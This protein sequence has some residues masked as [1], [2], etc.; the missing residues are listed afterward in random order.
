MDDCLFCKINAGDIPG[1]VIA[2]NANYLA[3]RDI[4]P[5][6]DTHV[7]VIPREHHDNLDRFLANGGDAHDMLQFV[8]QTAEGLGVGGKYRLIVNV[9]EQAGQVVHHLHWHILAGGRLPGF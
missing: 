5:K 4:A 8:S 3:F 7:L 1:D 9:G 6:A 2:E